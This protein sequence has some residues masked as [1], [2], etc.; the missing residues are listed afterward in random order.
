MF[1]ILVSSCAAC[2]EKMG[3]RKS[4]IAKRFLKVII[5]V[6]K[7]KSNNTTAN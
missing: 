3:R 1:T 5:F 7:A 6:T 4:Q 2:N